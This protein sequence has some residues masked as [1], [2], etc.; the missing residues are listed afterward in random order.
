MSYRKQSLLLQDDFFF[1]AL[2]FALRVI[3]L[4]FEWFIEQNCS[5][6]TYIYLYSKVRIRE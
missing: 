2:R 5:Y 4:D 3:V 6:D 1:S